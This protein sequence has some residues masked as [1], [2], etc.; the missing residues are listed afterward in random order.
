[1]RDKLA[2]LSLTEEQMDKIDAILK[3]ELKDKYVP[4]SRFNSLNEQ[5][6]KL[7]EDIAG[8][9]AQLESL[10]NASGDVDKL[11]KQIETL[12]A[13]NR[14]AKEEYDAS[15]KAMRRDDFIKSTLMEAGLLDA[16]YIPGVSAYLPINDLDID[17]VTSV[18][19]FKTKIAEAKTIASAWFK[20][21]EPPAKEIDGLR[22]NDPITKKNPSDERIDKNSYEYFLNQ[23]NN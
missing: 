3:E 20:S 14:K 2:E 5:K 1:M 6:K 12:Q 16:K 19:T 15:I 18:D 7:E 10:K 22:I 11:K 23:Y 13:D 9:D 21:D 17:S 8:Y 4:L